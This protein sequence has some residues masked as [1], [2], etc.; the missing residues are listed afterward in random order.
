[1]DLI[2]L[3]KVNRKLNINATQSS[4]KGW[5]RIVKRVANIA[6]SAAGVLLAAPLKLPG[7]LAQVVQ[8]IAL[9]AG[10]VKAAEKSENDE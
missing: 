9:F 3:I 4:G 10:V 6:G 7:K 2:L 8:Y 5:L 1:M